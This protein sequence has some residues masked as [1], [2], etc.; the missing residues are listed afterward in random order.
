[1]TAAPACLSR[2]NAFSKRSHEPWVVSLG[3]IPLAPTPALPRGQFGHEFHRPR[4]RGTV[5]DCM[6]CL[7]MQ[8]GAMRFEVQSFSVEVIT[9]NTEHTFEG[10][11]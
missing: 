10:V 8:C 7:C 6:A 11:R 4:A 3:R 9:L 2:L 5:T 1:M